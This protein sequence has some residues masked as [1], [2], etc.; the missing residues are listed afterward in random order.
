[1]SEPP[2]KIIPGKMSRPVTRLRVNELGQYDDHPSTD[3][4]LEVM[5]EYEFGESQFILTFIEVR[6]VD[7]REVHDR[8]SFLVPRDQMLEGI[9]Q[10]AEWREEQFNSSREQTQ[11]T[12]DAGSEQT[13][14]HRT[15]LKRGFR[16]LGKCFYRKTGAERVWTMVTDVR[17]AVPEC[18]TFRHQAGGFFFIGRNWGMVSE[19]G[20]EITE[21]EFDT[22]RR[23]LIKHVSNC[24]NPLLHDDQVHEFDPEYPRSLLAPSPVSHD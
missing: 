1:M 5:P 13:E 23:S 8:R 4:V 11:A 19:L 16:S 12:A 18:I 24:I 15:T 20:D 2:L 21:S 22:A 6:W 7:G 9:A 14:Q 3:V 17:G 10:A